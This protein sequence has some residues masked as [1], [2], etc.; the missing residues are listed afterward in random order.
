[1]ARDR[2]RFHPRTIA[3]LVELSPVAQEQIEDHLLDVLRHPTHRGSLGVVGTA[4]RWTRIR[5]MH[6]AFEV[7]G[8]GDVERTT[9]IVLMMKAL[10]AHKK[11]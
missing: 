8:A 5:R 9:L 1:M 10:P 3:V 7:S 4:I 11:N 6:V 2:I